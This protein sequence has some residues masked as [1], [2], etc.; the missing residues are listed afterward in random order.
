MLDRLFGGDRYAAQTHA[1]DAAS[2]RHQAISNN[3]ANVE[4]PH[5]KRQEVRFEEQLAQALDNKSK[6]GMGRKGEIGN[7]RATITRIGDTTSR[8]DGNN[9]TM[10]LEAA[11]LAENE[12]KYSVL[13]QSLGG[14]YSALKGV[15]NGGR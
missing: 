4:T 6:F 3:L 12:M 1:L 11:H 9:V 8:T 15:I 5:Y 10:E 7:V 2:L 14:Y 13:T